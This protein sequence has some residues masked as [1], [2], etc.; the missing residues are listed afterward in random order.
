MALNKWT[1]ACKILS[2]NTNIDDDEFAASIADLSPDFINRRED[3]KVNK[4]LFNKTLLDIAI[5]K[6]ATKAVALL[7]EKGANVNLLPTNDI[8]K[9]TSP[10]ELAVATENI[11]IIKL[12]IEKS[13]DPNNGYRSP[14]SIATTCGKN[15]IP[16]SKILL[17][18][19][20]DINKKS[21]AANI[22]PLKSAVIQ[23]NKKVYEYLLT[24]GATIDPDII[25]SIQAVPVG[26][27][28][29]QD[30][31]KR[32]VDINFANENGN[33]LHSLLDEAFI[34]KNLK[35]STIDIINLLSAAGINWH[36]RNNQMNEPLQEYISKFLKSKSISDIFKTVVAFCISKGAIL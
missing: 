27:S 12:L 2:Q 3:S 33:I 30:L 1:A 11:E 23:S 32:G 25:L 4:S 24:K 34:K 16:I 26:I 7:I 6:N 9:H 21:T 36:K 15:A 18:A 5:N 28:I 19:G 8:N 17:A 31:I 20:A 10:L 14:L 29:C 35:K 22:S 13:A